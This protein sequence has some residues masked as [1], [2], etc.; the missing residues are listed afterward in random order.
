MDNPAGPLV[1]LGSHETF[2][3]FNSFPIELRR[4]IWQATFVPRIVEILASEYCTAGFF[5]QATLPVAFCV[6]KESREEAKKHYKLSFGSFLQPAKIYF[7]F[8]I[9][10][11]YIDVALEEDG[12]HRLFGILKQ[13][14]L[15]RIKHVAIDEAY[16]DAEDPDRVVPPSP[17]TAGLR[18]A[19]KAM[20]SLKEV[21]V[22]REIE[23]D[24]QNWHQGRVPKVQIKFCHANELGDVNEDW[25]ASA[26]ELPDV[27]RELRAWKL[28]KSVRKKAM[29]GWRTNM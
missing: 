25:I 3:Q 2:P 19:L 11:L 8:N 26:G 24:S 9:D 6:S 4:M 27:G 5:S 29:Y 14:E 13:D 1:S 22:V 12:L 7:N 23:D 10:T 20:T 18:M 17:M 28:E 16:L 21:T 15:S